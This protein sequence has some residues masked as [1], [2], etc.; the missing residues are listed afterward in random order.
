MEVKSSEAQHDIKTKQRQGQA[1]RQEAKASSSLARKRALT[2]T[3]GGSGS[4]GAKKARRD[5][6]RFDVSRL[7]A[8]V[9]V[10]VVLPG[11]R[12][13]HVQGVFAGVDL[14]E[15]E[16][17]MDYRPATNPEVQII[18]PFTG[19]RIPLPRDKAFY[20]DDE[21]LRYSYGALEDV[22][23]KPWPPALLAIRD[24]RFT[25]FGE[26]YTSCVVNR[27][28]TG[29]NYIGWHRDK[30]HDMHPTVGT[31]TVSFGATR[32]FQLGKP[33]KTMKECKGHEG[34]AKAKTVV[35]MTDIVTVQLAHGDVF[36][37]D[38]DTNR[39]YQHQVP[40]CSAK[41]V[42]QP[43]CGLTF[44]NI[45]GQHAADPTGKTSV[46]KGKKSKK[47]SSQTTL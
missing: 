43:R 25:T 15:L 34:K 40:K 5:P 44:R 31:C 3:D 17:Q 11:R 4:S 26:Y 21:T 1:Q 22:V 8:S 18:Q 9:S 27:Y 16:S 42:Q 32:P 20:G 24:R 36:Y 12:C 6:G 39:A 13:Y 38:A 45:V 33:V 10:H 7:P 47:R 37:L 23:F 46:A 2:R 30:D 28:M 14:V 19:K 35:V 41:Q 29:D